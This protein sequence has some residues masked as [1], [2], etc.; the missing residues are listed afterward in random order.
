MIPLSSTILFNKIND[1]QDD[2]GFK[3]RA[4]KVI[5]S[6]KVWGAL[7][8]HQISRR[9][10]TITALKSDLGFHLTF[11]LSGVYPIKP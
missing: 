3:F 8:A 4:E 11:H 10:E 9:F 2:A 5:K 7:L 1:L 6:Y